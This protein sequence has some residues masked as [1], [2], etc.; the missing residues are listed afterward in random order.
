MNSSF[1]HN[2]ELVGI[3]EIGVR[4]ELS[5]ERVRQL[6]RS[7]DL[8]APVGRLG[9]QEIWR[10]EDIEGWAISTERLTRS[11]D[12]SRQL[13]RAWL[14]SSSR[15]QLVVDEIVGWGFESRNVVHVRIWDPIDSFSEPSVVLLGNLEDNRGNSV[16]NRIE[17]VAGL[18]A[19]RFLG[20][21]GKEA[22][23]YE[24]WSGG[25]IHSGPT[26][27]NV[28]FSIQRSAAQKSTSPLSS[29]GFK[30]ASPSWRETDRHEIERLIGGPLVVYTWGTYTAELVQAVKD[31]PEGAVSAEWDPDGSVPAS[32]AFEILTN[33]FVGQPGTE[34]AVNEFL[35]SKKF[36]TVASVLLADH[37]VASRERA[38][39]Y[40]VWQ[41]PDAPV[42][43]IVADPH[44]ADALRKAA[45][46]MRIRGVD[47]GDAWET[48]SAIRE[49][50]ASISPEDRLQLVPACGSGLSRL[51]WWEAGIP[52]LEDPRQGA[53]GPIARIERLDETYREMSWL[54][55][56]RFAESAVC[57][58]LDSECE[59][60]RVWDTPSYRL[61]GP[62]SATK[63]ISRK[64]LDGL[65]WSSVPNDETYRIE[66]LKQFASAEF[67]TKPLEFNG[68]GFDR[69]GR[70]VLL[71][72]N[73]KMFWAEWP[74]G[75]YGSTDLDQMVCAD[76]LR[77]SGAAP[78]YLVSPD[79]RIDPLPGPTNF[80]SPPEFRWGYFGTGP[81]N[82]T[83]AIV[84]AIRSATSHLSDEDEARIRSVVSAKVGSSRTPAWTLRQVVEEALLD[85]DEPK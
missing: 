54:E 77:E 78:V 48:L 55:V 74:V 46:E 14:P 8:P 35:S 85:S 51:T 39:G 82:L 79:G 80:P 83:S 19:A 68:C 65:S 4:L 41:D 62:F 84:D 38:A 43:L 72:K 58:Y 50:L 56:F 3:S 63:A 59:A 1:I 49:V 53:L 22:Q 73:K 57:R 33:A 6:A 23:F 20:S 60:Y 17:E 29:V 25:P 45:S 52:E 5:A 37:S 9:R 2:G 69:D 31:S 47:H 12:N 10:W 27:D 15:L 76:P 70:V 32:R 81:S 71:S 13:V 28:T 66:R 18:V 7:G 40:T 34:R 21:R 16:T 36:L 42:Q 26:Y 64:Y 30:F 67:A 11:V 61:A 24:F 75:T 44:Q